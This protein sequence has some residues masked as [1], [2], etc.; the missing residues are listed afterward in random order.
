MTLG[1]ACS[2]AGEL[3]ATSSLMT[4]DVYRWGLRQLQ[5]L[6]ALCAGAERAAVQAVHPTGREPPA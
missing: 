5:L 4:F 2:G 3:V 6:Q 1:V